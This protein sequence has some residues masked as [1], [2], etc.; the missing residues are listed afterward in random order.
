MQ[1]P[2][3]QWKGTLTGIQPRIRLTRSFDQR[4]HE[5]LG[6]A[7]C[8]ENNAADAVVVGVGPSAQAKHGFRVGGAVSGEAIPVT[9]PERD[10]VELH[11]VS[12]I[13][14]QPPR[15]EATPPPP[16]NNVAPDLAV[17]RQRGH[18]RLD[19]RT[20]DRSCRSC[21]WGAN[22]PVVLIIDQWKPD[23]RRHRVETFCYGPKS[24]SL[25]RAGPTR[26]VPGRHGMS[27]EEEDWVDEDA[28]SHRGPDE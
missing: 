13:V 19:A 8:V 18:R 21:I 17:Y 27:W 5:Y 7:L 14:W 23:I 28:T 1:Q 25:Y 22:M 4:F 10:T 16:W 6:Y 24:C 12:R 3:I 9:D 11:R 2:K 26:K 20:Y 15:E